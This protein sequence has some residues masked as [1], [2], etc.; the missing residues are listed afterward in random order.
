M[1]VS[2]LSY[3]AYTAVQFYPTFYTLIPAAVLLG[4]GAAPLVWLIF[5]IL[6]FKK[7]FLKIIYR[8]F[9]G[10]LKVSI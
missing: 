3:A 1:V 4:L 10:Q 9:S 6:I 8:T 2:Q 7:L 5:P